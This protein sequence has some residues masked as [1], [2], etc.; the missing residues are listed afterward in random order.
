MTTQELPSQ[1]KLEKPT[2]ADST[3]LS[4]MMA[5]GFAEKG[6][7]AEDVKTGYEL[8]FC[9]NAQRIESCRVVR[10]E[11]NGMILGAIQLQLPGD[12]GDPSQPEWLNHK[13]VPGECYLEWITCRPEV[14]SMQN[15]TAVT[16][17]CNVLTPPRYLCKA[18]GK[19][20]GSTLMK[21]GDE[22][23]TADGCDFI[24]LGVVGA[25]TSAIRLYERK[26]FVITPH[27]DCVDNFFESMFVFCCLGCKYWTVH[28]MKKPLKSAGSD[29]AAA[30]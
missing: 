27:G 20:I 15:R 2:A 16:I 10:D 19:G 1:W 22:K 14:I 13:L 12:K 9:E 30:V 18:T 26:G 17:P 23:A 3:E 7:N 8:A 5:L 21:W 24:S 4:A 29:E 28:Y 11:A 6:L 25:N